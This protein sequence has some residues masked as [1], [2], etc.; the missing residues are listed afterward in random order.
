MQAEKTV[1]FDV[2]TRERFRAKV[3]DDGPIVH[4][5]LGPCWLWTAAV[6]KEGY[7]RFRHL[8]KTGAGAHRISYEMHVGSVPDGMFVCHKCDNRAC[9][10]PAHLFVGTHTDN[11][12]DMKAKG[13]AKGGV[14]R[15]HRWNAADRELDRALDAV[16]SALDSRTSR[17]ILDRPAIRRRGET[18]GLFEAEGGRQGGAAYQQDVVSG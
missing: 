8:S 5:T 9:V 14:Q 1:A 2:K 12:D 16:A 18:S 11:M 17:G 4:P 15:G 10:N 13:R 6:T 7:G 3:N